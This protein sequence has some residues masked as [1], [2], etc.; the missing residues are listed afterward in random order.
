MERSI[1]CLAPPSALRYSPAIV[2][3]DTANTDAEDLHLQEFLRR[4]PQDFHLKLLDEST[5][6]YL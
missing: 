6:G 3:N 1:C 4:L 5:V 2:L